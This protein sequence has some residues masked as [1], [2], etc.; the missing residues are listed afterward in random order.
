MVKLDIGC[1]P[2]KKE[3]YFGVDAIAFDGVDLVFDVANRKKPWPWKAGEVEAVHMSHVFEHF[4]ALERVWVINELWRVLAPAGDATII[5]PYW[6]SSRAYGDPTHQ[7]PPVG[8]MTWYYL[9][10]SWRMANAP[11]ADAQYRPGMYECD[12]VVT[13][14]Y[15]LH[16]EIQKRNDEFQA[17]AVNWYKEAAQDMIATLKRRPG[18]VS[19]KPLST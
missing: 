7:W 16:P 14:G 18:D 13:W 11:H 8:E 3:G 5:V 6:G 15:S 2:N 9:D 19:A 17:F 1:G 12:F 4:T 10:R